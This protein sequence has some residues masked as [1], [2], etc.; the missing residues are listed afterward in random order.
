M[1]YSWNDNLYE[2]IPRLKI[3]PIIQIIPNTILEEHRKVHKFLLLKIFEIEF[4]IENI[5]KIFA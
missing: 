1:T 4:I 2:D 3:I 5:W